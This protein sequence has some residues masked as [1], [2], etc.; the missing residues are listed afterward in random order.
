MKCPELGRLCSAFLFIWQVKVT[1]AAQYVVV[2]FE[3]DVR[4]VASS[5]CLLNVR[6][7]GREREIWYFYFDSIFFFFF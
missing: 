5:R 6:Q 2:K 4:M 1:I 3:T 7:G